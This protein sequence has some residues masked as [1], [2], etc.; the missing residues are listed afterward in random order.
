MLPCLFAALTCVPIAWAEL[1]EML[2]EFHTSAET[3]NSQETS[4]APDQCEAWIARFE[5]AVA[6]NPDDPRLPFATNELATLYASIGEEREAFRLFEQ[7]HDNERANLDAR[8][9]AVQRAQNLRLR[10]TDSGHDAFPY[11]DKM[12][13]LAGF[14]ESQGAVLVASEAVQNARKTKYYKA[15]MLQQ[16]ANRRA[17]QLKEQG[18]T[19]KAYQVKLDYLTESLAYMDEDLQDTRPNPRDVAGDSARAWVLLEAAKMASQQAKLGRTLHVEETEISHSHEHSVAFCEEILTDYQDSGHALQLAGELLLRESF[20]IMTSPEAYLR[21]ARELKGQVDV[22]LEVISALLSVS[23]KLCKPTQTPV[24]LALA[25]GL[26]DLAL[27][28]EEEW[29]ATEFKSHGGYHEALLRKGIALVGLGKIEEA[30]ELLSLQAR[31]NPDYFPSLRKKLQLQIEHAR[32]EAHSSS[33]NCLKNLTKD[34]RTTRK[35]PHLTPQPHPR[36][37]PPGPTPEPRPSPRTPDK[38]GHL[39]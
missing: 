16:E 12:K 32:G 2:T 33:R 13:E 24:E 27:E 8:F 31:L 23:S 17:A 20:P 26:L 14:A 4:P 10:N 11:F 36:P 19:D 34:L 29:Y 35:R 21:R 3:D 6:E 7:V 30:Q 39:V 18:D 9:A 37:L 28:L 22:G 1:A 25:T 38:E 5:E 15:L